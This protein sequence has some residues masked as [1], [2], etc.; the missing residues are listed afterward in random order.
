MLEADD[1]VPPVNRSLGCIFDSK[2]M[3]R[4]ISMAALVD[5][6]KPIIMIKTEEQPKANCDVPAFHK[7]VKSEERKERCHSYWSTNKDEQ[8]M[9]WQA[10]SP[11]NNEW[12]KAEIRIPAGCEK[13]KLLLEG[14][15]KSKA[16]SICLDHFDFVD[17]TKLDLPKICSSEEFACANGQCIDISLLCDYQWDCLDG[18]D[19]DLSAC[20]NYTLCDF[21]SDLCEW[22]TLNTKD[23]Q[24]SLMKGQVSGDSEL[25]ARDHTTNSSRGNFI[26]VTGSPEA[27]T[28]PVISQLSSPVF[29]KLSKDAT[30]CQH[31][32]NIFGEGGKG[33]AGK[34]GMEFVQLCWILKE[35]YGVRG[36][37]KH[38]ISRPKSSTDL[39]VLKPTLNI[40]QQCDVVVK[41]E[42]YSQVGI[43]AA[44]G[45]KDGGWIAGGLLR[46]P[47]RRSLGAAHKP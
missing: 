3:A 5:K 16:S 14:T 31:Q 11:T 33:Q 18:S 45:Y 4:Y 15:I 24:W 43:S 35:K 41:R 23:V 28:K 47:I 34:N 42:G 30:P 8:V 19:E 32:E 1:R 17:S 13:N 39:A 36:K 12:V 25:P 40:S 20:A 29:T 22:K 6:P 10:S 27:N 21:E 38:F 46:H 26:H 37:G 44:Q 9:L 2:R 7:T